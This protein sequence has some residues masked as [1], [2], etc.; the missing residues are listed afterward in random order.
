MAF[1]SRIPLP[2]S[3]VQINTNLPGDNKSHCNRALCKEREHSELVNQNTQFQCEV[4]FATSK[5]NQVEKKIENK[6]ETLHNLLKHANTFNKNH[7]TLKSKKNQTLL[8]QGGLPKI[9][10][11]VEKSKNIQFITE[12][13]ELPPNIITTSGIQQKSNLTCLEIKKNTI[14]TSIVKEDDDMLSKDA[15]TISHFEWSDDDIHSKQISLSIPQSIS[16]DCE[17]LN[18]ATTKTS[19]NKVVCEEPS[20]FFKKKFEDNKIFESRM[21]LGK[22]IRRGSYIDSDRKKEYKQIRY[23]DSPPGSP[24]CGW[25]S[26]IE[27]DVEE[28]PFKIP[29]FFNKI[30][31]NIDDIRRP[32]DE[33]DVGS[34]IIDGLHLI[35]SLHTLENDGECI[36]ENIK[37]FNDKDVKYDYAKQSMKNMEKIM[38]DCNINNIMEEKKMSTGVIHENFDLE[39]DGDFI[40]QNSKFVETML[41]EDCGF[42][43]QNCS[44][45]DQKEKEC[46]IS[47]LFDNSSYDPNINNEV[48]CDTWKLKDVHVENELE[49]ILHTF[50]IYFYSTYSIM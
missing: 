15:K 13:L 3:T 40:L 43:K 1:G 45:N 47:N 50:Y 38:L 30:C 44:F 33:V 22:N 34:T 21:G 28:K 6:A 41:D 14:E 2:L 8:D 37:F 39:N 7:A 23:L 9:N 17:T 12:E 32:N 31:D 25:K 11:F 27:D 46:H 19:T 4:P 49:G 42:G 10:E 36:E 29:S 26:N 5:K 16:L 18:V 20:S 35:D 24:P 48:T